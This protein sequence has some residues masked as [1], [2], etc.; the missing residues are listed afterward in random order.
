M[1]NSLE[2]LPGGGYRNALQASDATAPPA[3]GTL[4]AAAGPRAA[5][6][7]AC[8]ARRPAVAALAAASCTAFKAS[9]E[10]ISVRAVANGMPATRRSIRFR[11]RS[12]LSA[13]R[14]DWLIASIISRSFELAACKG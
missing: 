14:S 12:P 11:G 2:L 6:D 5:R 3:G 1:C 7:A 4:P 10:W 13:G 8:A 9:N